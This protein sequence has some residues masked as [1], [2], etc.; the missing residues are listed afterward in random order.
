MTV[1][2]KKKK[3]PRYIENSLVNPHRLGR[4]STSAKSTGFVKA[5][6]RLSWDRRLVT[7]RRNR[8]SSLRVSSSSS[9]NRLASSSVS[10]GGG[11]G[12]ATGSASRKST[13]EDGRQTDDRCAHT[14][15]FKCT[16]TGV[17]TNALNASGS[18]YLK[19]QIAIRTFH[20]TAKQ[21]VTE[22]KL[23]SSIPPLTLWRFSPSPALFLETGALEDWWRIRSLKKLRLSLLVGGWTQKISPYSTLNK[24]CN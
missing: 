24:S 12:A 4:K 19:M 17:T 2:H 1:T 10:W 6:K 13:T 21:Q 23:R 8:R 9:S 14:I 7:S 20:N 22:N 16:R 3:N 11:S 18:I 15:N 5:L